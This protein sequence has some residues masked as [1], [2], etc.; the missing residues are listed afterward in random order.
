MWLYFSARH[1]PFYE[2]VGPIQGEH[3]S[4]RVILRTDSSS[5]PIRS[6]R[7]AFFVSGCHTRSAVYSREVPS[8]QIDSSHGS[9]LYPSLIQLSNSKRLPPSL[10]SMF[11]SGLHYNNVHHRGSFETQTYEAVRSDRCDVSSLF[12]ASSTLIVYF[13]LDDRS[14][15]I[16]GQQSSRRQSLR[17]G[18]HWDAFL[19]GTCWLY[20]YDRL[21]KN[22]AQTSNC[23]IDAIRLLCLSLFDIQSACCR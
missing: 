19:C 10:D 14:E 21:C 20:F 2:W 7:S 15:F 6:K 9:F 11:E 22:K 16:P 4:S 3:V 13:A 17:C 23:L 5:R 8:D 18:A 12:L 1:T